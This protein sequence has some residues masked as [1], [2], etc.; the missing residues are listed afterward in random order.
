MACLETGVARVAA[1][2]ANHERRARSGVG[3]AYAPGGWVYARA[4]EEAGQRWG[5][6]WPQS[7]VV[8]VVGKEGE[9]VGRYL[10]VG[11]RA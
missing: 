5:I 8:G 7:A 1:A 9:N 11:G 4:V 6:D 3:P 2:E 10:L